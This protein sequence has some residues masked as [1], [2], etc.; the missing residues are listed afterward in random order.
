MKKEIIKNV[1]SGYG[2]IIL[3]LAL[4]T[5][6]VALLIL[7]NFLGLFALL[8]FIFI[9]AGLFINNPNEVKALTLFGEYKGSVHQ[10]GFLWANPFLKKQNISLRARNTN[11]PNLKVNEKNGNPIEIATV[12]VWKVVDSYKALFEV[13]NF[14][15]YIELQ[16]E[17]AL[18]HLAQS[19]PYDKHGY[20]DHSITLRDGG[21]AVNELLEKELNERLAPA[22][23]E[24][25]EARISHLA[26]APEIAHAMLQKQQASA[27]VAARQL[28]VE[29]AVGMVEMALAK[30]SEKKV[31]EL[32]EERK[33]SMVSNML[34]V[35]CGDKNV[36]PV[37]NT[38]TLYS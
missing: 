25:I 8:L 21:E 32:D 33:A 26:Y 6:G 27:I 22:G 12:L 4:L 29:G 36:S 1:S 10:P 24:I 20:D 7:K 3:A 37:I 17:A 2:M 19:C 38:G 11:G 31:V 35:L 23:I 34:V 30:L 14:T 16:S 9:V 5:A 13:E 15:K 18:R 28:I